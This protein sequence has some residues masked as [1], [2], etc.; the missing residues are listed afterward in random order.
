MRRARYGLRALWICV[1][2]ALAAPLALPP[3]EA[4]AKSSYESAYG[5]DRTWNA[6]MRL[7]RVDLGLKISEKDEGAG[8]LLFDYLSPESGKKPVP[9]SMEFIRSKDSGAVR[10]V[11]Q[12][13]QMPGYHEQVVVDSLARK[14]RNEY[15]DPPKRPTPPPAPKDAGADGEAPES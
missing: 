6:G 14:L 8:Y 12:I 15:G 11:V 7:V 9:G 2:L 13:P 1:T 3:E 4:S 5:F 10:V